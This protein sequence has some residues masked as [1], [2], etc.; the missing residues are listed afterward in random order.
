MPFANTTRRWGPASDRDRFVNPARRL[1][2]VAVVD[3][4]A[5]RGTAGHSSGALVKF[6]QA[7]QPTTRHHPVR[8][9]KHCDWPVGSLFA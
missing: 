8:N 6:L 3:S 7:N 2:L 1:E 5:D 4:R 9:E